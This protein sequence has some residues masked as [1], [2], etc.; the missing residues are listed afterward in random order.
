M[1]APPRPSRHRPALG[2]ARDLPV[3]DDNRRIPQARRVDAIHNIHVGDGNDPRFRPLRLCAERDEEKRDQS[4][5]TTKHRDH[6]E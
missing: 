6:P 5:G 4:E 1:A 2:D 3:P